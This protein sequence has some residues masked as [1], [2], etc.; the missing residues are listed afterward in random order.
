[1]STNITA[2]SDSASKTGAAAE[3][4]LSSAKNMSENS[5]ALT[6]RVKA[7]ILELRKGPLDRRER[8]DADYA[9]PERRQDVQE[10]KPA[11]RSGWAA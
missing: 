9:G 5:A 8:Q 11:P 3:T 7:F 4:V 2:V 10:T 1:V 6:E